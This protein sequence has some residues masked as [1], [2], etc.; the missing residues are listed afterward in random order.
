MPRHRTETGLAAIPR[1]EV[2]ADHAAFQKTFPFRESH[3]RGAVYLGTGILA[4]L[5]FVAFCRIN[6]KTSCPIVSAGTI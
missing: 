5:A 2:A 3:P 4:F 6:W 1:G